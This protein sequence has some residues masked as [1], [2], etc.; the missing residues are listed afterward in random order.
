M[1]VNI[2]SPQIIVIRTLKSPNI[3]NDYKLLIAKIPIQTQKYKKQEQFYIDKLNI[4]SLEVE[5][6][7]IMYKS[8][9]DTI[10]L[11]KMMIQFTLSAK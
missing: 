9:L 2:N 6:V 8:R 3:G 7:Q 10:Q 5:S 4:E 11:W 1:K